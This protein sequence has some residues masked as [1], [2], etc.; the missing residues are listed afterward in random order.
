[1][2]RVH[3]EGKRFRDFGQRTFICFSRVSMLV[4]NM[5][6]DELERYGRYK[7][8]FPAMLGAADSK[9]KALDIEQALIKQTQDISLS[10]KQV[11]DT[12]E[13]LS[14][15]FVQNQEKTMNIMRKMLQE[16]DFKI[17]AM[18]LDEDQEQYLVNRIDQGIIEAEVV[19]DQSES[20]NAAFHH[21]SNLL[22]VLA[23]QQE[24]ITDDVRRSHGAGEEKRRRGGWHG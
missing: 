15:A 23:E 5:P 6:L 11:G 10:F 7:D 12:L 14:D 24:K 22:A 1:M 20:L 18:G 13:G 3:Q 4:K 9:T 16:L 19:M 17:P 8:L 21:I 2:I